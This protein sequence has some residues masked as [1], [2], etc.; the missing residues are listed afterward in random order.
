MS[1][2]IIATASLF[3]STKRVVL[4]LEADW[5]SFV[6][7]RPKPDRRQSHVDMP[8]GLERRA[9]RQPSHAKEPVSS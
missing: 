4:E 1:S 2:K 6:A 8:M 9:A 7:L 3:V 5:A